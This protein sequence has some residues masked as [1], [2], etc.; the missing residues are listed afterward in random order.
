MLVFNLHSRICFGVDC[1]YT[2]SLIAHVSCISIISVDLQF[3]IVEMVI[4]GFSY[5]FEGLLYVDMGL[6]HVGGYLT[7]ILCLY[8]YPMCCSNY[9]CSSH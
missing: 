6:L 9:I 7:H 2:D 8:A 3:I 5:Q 4:W 1:I